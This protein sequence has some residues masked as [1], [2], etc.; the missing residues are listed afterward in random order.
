MFNIKIFQL[1][2]SIYL[3]DQKFR[4][5]NCNAYCYKETRIPNLDF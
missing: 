2:F 3:R 5:N 1:E 4:I